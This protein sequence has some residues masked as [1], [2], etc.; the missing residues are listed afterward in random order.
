[1]KDGALVDVVET[2]SVTEQTLT[3][4]MVGRDLEDY[5]PDRDTNVGEVILQI[6]GMATEEVG[7]QDL[8]DIN[9]TLHKGEILGIYGLVGSGRTE[10]AKTIFGVLPQTAGKT[11]V[12]GKEVTIRSPRQAITLG[13]G[14]LV[15]DRKDEGLVLD[16]TVKANI[17]LANYPGISHLGWIL[18]DRET[19]IA[20][21]FV[22]KLSIKTPFLS[23]VS[24]SLSGGNQQKLVLSKWLFRDAKILIF[25]EPTRG[26]DVGTKSEIYQLMD[27]LV[28]HGVGIIM[29]SAE[30]NEILAMADRVIVMR[31]G[32][33]AGEVSRS[34]ASEE[35][36][37]SIAMGVEN[38]GTTK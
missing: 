34:E 13:L 9:L 10:L 36:L 26:I 1:L 15:E 27:E 14:L 31:N 5:F 24:R 17:T 19:K 20:Q 11:I 2:S 38:H 8:S 35:K 33:I 28:N 3:N 4:L 16:A 23:T 12:D 18:F 22:D 32:R 29:I 25:D 7:T 6:E 37:V 21:E 30:L